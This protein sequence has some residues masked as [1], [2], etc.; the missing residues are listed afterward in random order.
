[1]LMAA[2]ESPLLSPS[3]WASGAM[4]SGLEIDV[5]LPI[6]ADIEALLVYR[7]KGAEEAWV[8]PVDVCY[9]LVGRIRRRW[10]GFD[11]GADVHA[12][13]DGFFANLAERRSAACQV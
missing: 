6:E 13:I 10:R 2:P 4:E 12:E 7:R 8:V 11:G 3:S 1:M 9:E 5:P